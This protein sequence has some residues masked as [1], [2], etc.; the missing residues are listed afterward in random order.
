MTDE[1][2]DL[3]SPEDLAVIAQAKDRAIR[4]A[5]QAETVVAQA[6]VA[7]LEHR[8]L[9]QHMFLKYSIPITGRVD[10]NT[11]QITW[12]ELSELTSGE[13]AEETANESK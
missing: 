10:E 5:Q 2:P 4:A 11:G 1:R 8:T 9:V 13:V 3:I 7:E 6:K 12:P